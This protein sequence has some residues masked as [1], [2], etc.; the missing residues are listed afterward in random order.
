LPS[1][2][3]RVF[4]HAMSC[5]LSLSAQD[6]TKGAMKALRIDVLAALQVMQCLEAREV[7]KPVADGLEAILVA[8]LGH[9]AELPRRQSIQLLNSL[10]S[11][12]DW[13][14]RLHV[15]GSFWVA[16]HSF[17]SVTLFRQ[18]TLWSLSYAAL[19]THFQLMLLFVSPLA[20]QPL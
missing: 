19:V 13:E 14:V 1:Q 18:H 7:C 20:S 10:Y 8:T 2:L 4:H 15:L 12:A 17:S 11:G 16:F 3:P 9:F 5:L 6:Q